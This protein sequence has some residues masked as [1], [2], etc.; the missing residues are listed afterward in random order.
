MILA[1][2]LYFS[3]MN[4]LFCSLFNEKSYI[5]KSL[6]IIREFPGGLVVM[7]SLLRMKFQSLVRELRSHK[8]PATK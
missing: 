4:Q 6:C 8:I 1:K 5:L 7:L 3:I 2:F